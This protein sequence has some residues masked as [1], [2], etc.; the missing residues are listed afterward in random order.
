MI[1][2]VS[3]SLLKAADRLAPTGMATFVRPAIPVRKGSIWN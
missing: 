3:R 1:A 2:N